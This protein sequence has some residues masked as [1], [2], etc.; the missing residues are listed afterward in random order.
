MR[1]LF[2]LLAILTIATM[3][4][5][6]GGGAA[7]PAPAAPSGDAAPTGGNADNGKVLFSQAVLAGN[8]GCSTCHSLEPG[9]VIVGPS[10]AGIGTRAASTVAGQ[11]AEQYIRTSIAKTNEHLAKGCNAADLN[12]DC[13]ASVMPQDWEQKLKPA[14]LNDLVAYLQ[15]LK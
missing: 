10:M 15:T 11:T 5:A 13:P 2:V 9:K 7:E 6:C 12:A 8:A 4:A 14:E 1:K 3:L